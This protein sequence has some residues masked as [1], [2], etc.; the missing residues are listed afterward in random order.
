MDSS[1]FDIILKIYD[2]QLWRILISL[3]TITNAVKFVC[4][5]YLYFPHK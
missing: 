1:Q 4:S 5:S 2:G 3:A